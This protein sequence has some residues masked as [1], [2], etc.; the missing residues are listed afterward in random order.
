MTNSITKQQDPVEEGI[1][2]W[3]ETKVQAK[4]A[5]E[6]CRVAEQR[7]IAAESRCDLLE[8][9]KEQDRATIDHLRAE[10]HEINAHLD[11]FAVMVLD[12]LEKR[13][14]GPY[15]ARGSRQQSVEETRRLVHQ[16]GGAI[17]ED[18]GAARI[19]HKFRPAEFT[20]LPEPPAEPPK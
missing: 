9:Q 16:N 7:A 13:K 10:L 14:I 1:A 6:R 20:A 17:A 3:H 15:R 5:V 19:A 18:D 11:C 12:A 8:S 4:E 2:R